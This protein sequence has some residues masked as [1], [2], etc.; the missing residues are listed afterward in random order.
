MG[1][2]NE[3][4]ICNIIGHSYIFRQKPKCNVEVQICTKWYQPDRND[5]SKNLYDK[6]FVHHSL[7]C[8]IYV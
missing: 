2:D 1:I 8:V 3:S 4:V 5:L 7:Q 6:T